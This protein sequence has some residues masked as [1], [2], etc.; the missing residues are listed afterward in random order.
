[1]ARQEFNGK[2]F[3]TIKF[4]IYIDGKSKYLAGYTIE[5]TDRKIA[6]RALKAKADELERFNNLMLG[7]EIKM[8]ELK[9]E[10]NELLKKSG[11]KLKYR[12]PV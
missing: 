3:T 1:M 12:I 11:K 9:K 7:R 2:H 6:E 10:I 4:P 8:I 5:I